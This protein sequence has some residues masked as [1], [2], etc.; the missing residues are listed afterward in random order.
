MT[1]RNMT[2]ARSGREVANQFVIEDGK[3]VVFQSYETPIALYNKE[4]KVCIVNIDYFDYSVT[5]SKYFNQFIREYVDYA[6]DTKILKKALNDYTNYK[7]E[8]GV[9]FV[10]LRGYDF[11]GIGSEF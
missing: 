10:G 5:T 8:N 7:S 9:G 11:N 3:R 4:T 1:V 2:S 6:I